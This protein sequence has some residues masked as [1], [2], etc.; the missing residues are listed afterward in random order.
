MPQTQIALPLRRRGSVLA[1]L[2]NAVQTATLRRR[3]RRQLAALDLHLL[4]D[5]GLDSLTAESECAKPFWK[6]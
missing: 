3:E 2:I 5:I 4:R 6:D 1:R